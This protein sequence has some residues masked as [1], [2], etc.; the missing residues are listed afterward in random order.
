MRM[1][2]AIVLGFILCCVSCSRDSEMILTYKGGGISR[3]E[4]VRWLKERA[5]DAKGSEK[6]REML[7]QE[8]QSMAIQRIARL[9][10]G[11]EGYEK[12]ERFSFLIDDVKRRYLCSFL[13]DRI[14]KQRGYRETAFRV[15][16]ILL[17]AEGGGAPSAEVLARA[18]SAIGE[19]ESGARFEDV[20]KKYSMHPSRNQGGDI[21]YMLREQ[22]PPAYADAVSSLSKGG[23]TREPVFLP[24][25]KS[26]CVLFL[27]DAVEITPKNIER[28]LP[29]DQRRG[30]IRDLIFVKMKSEYVRGLERAQGARFN[31]ASVFSANPAQPIFTIGA[32][33]FT[34]RDLR[35][36]IGMM[37]GIMK[38]GAESADAASV[39]NI[40]REYYMDTLLEREAIRQGLD[41]EKEY[42][43]K[44]EEA[45][46]SYLTGDYIEY[47]STR[48]LKITAA[49]L[50]REYERNKGALYSTVSMIDGRPVR[51]PIPFEKIKGRIEGELRMRKR[52]EG[53]EIWMKRIFQEYDVTI[54]AEFTGKSA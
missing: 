38:E 26:V 7:L 43:E 24:A 51:L 54:S 28:A 52:I 50:R 41:R 35:S 8:L 42:L 23:Y 32:S 10:A 18:R 1:V 17:P 20:V 13:M 25:L 3:G 31:E 49:E 5:P 44:I 9:E 14:S 34:V 33:S 40:A 39:M 2:C 12:S 6:N 21:G 11:R 48:D 19:L 30:Q 27:E 45:K 46:E 15:R 22:M 36:R 53:R 4:F 37:Q 47:A 29:D 16:Q